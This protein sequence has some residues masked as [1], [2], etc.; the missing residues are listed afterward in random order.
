MLR[1][2][3]ENLA[4]QNEL[5][6]QSVEA[7]TLERDAAN[8]QLQAVKDDTATSAAEH[9]QLSQEH[10]ELQGEVAELKASVEKLTQVRQL[11]IGVGVPFFVFISGFCFVP[12]S[13]QQIEGAR[14]A[15]VERAAS[16]CSSRTGAMDKHE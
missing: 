14:S 7:L 2:E 16:V 15:G 8:Q 3:N 13:K 11:G 10:T 5:L 12:G 6:T 4:Q 9:Q 1:E